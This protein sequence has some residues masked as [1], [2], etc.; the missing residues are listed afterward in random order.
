MKFSFAV[1]CTGLIYLKTSFRLFEVALLKVLVVY[2][3]VS[4]NKNT[5]KVAE[6]IG[7]WLKAK[8][9]EAQS[10]YAEEVDALTVKDYDCLIVGSPTHAWMEP[11]LIKKFLDRLKTASFVGKKAAAFDTRTKSRLS[12]GVISGIEGK[13]KQLGFKIIVP[14]LV[15]YV[16]GSKESPALFNGE[17]EKAKKFAEELTKAPQ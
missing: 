2:D 5:E 4:V 10:V 1:S 7:D 8:G 15:T 13:L 16:Q 3:S 12:G 11:P 6:A 14:G 9:I 17:L